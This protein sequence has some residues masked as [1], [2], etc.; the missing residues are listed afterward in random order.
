VSFESGEWRQVA[1]AVS[2]DLTA[3][4]AGRTLLPNTNIWL[5]DIAPMADK[6]ECVSH[7]LLALAAAYVLDYK[8]I[9]EIQARANHHYKRAVD[10]IGR[11]MRNQKF[12]EVGKDD[13]VVGALILLLS[14]DVSYHSDASSFQHS[15]IY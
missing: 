14:D 6:D 10:L 11:A 9:P 3:F 4:C 5:R 7:S 2:L 8:P 1:D 15:T 13:A 12:R